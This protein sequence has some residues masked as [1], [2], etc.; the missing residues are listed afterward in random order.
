MP[1]AYPMVS[2]Q[3]AEVAEEVPGAEIGVRTFGGIGKEIACVVAATDEAQDALDA[4]Y[5]GSLVRDAKI[6]YPVD[7]DEARRREMPPTWA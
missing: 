7:V 3:A 2:D 4:R 1:M 5:S 6:D